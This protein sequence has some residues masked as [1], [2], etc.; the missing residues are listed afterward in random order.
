MDGI[1]GSNPHLIAAQ[2]KVDAAKRALKE[3]SSGSKEVNPYDWAGDYCDAD[4]E[5]ASAESALKKA[6]EKAARMAA[7]QL[8]NKG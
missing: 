4:G 7:A 3:I 6:Q 8:R 1:C 5:V 2:A